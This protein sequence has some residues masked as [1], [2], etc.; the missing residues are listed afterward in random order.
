MTLPGIY[1]LKGDVLK[2]CF[3]FPF[4]MKFDKLGKRPDRIRQQA[5]WR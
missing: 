3:P 1:E 2:V 5:R 4:G